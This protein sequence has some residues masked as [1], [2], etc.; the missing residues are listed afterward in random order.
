MT[1]CNDLYLM[2]KK[3]GKMEFSNIPKVKVKVTQSCPALC[4][5]IQ[6]M[7]FSRPEY[8]SG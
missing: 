8:W 3:L 6:F 4:N 2:I 1:R 7:E 5:P